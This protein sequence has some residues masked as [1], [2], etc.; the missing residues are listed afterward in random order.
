MITNNFSR[1]VSKCHSA[2]TL[3]KKALLR[4]VTVMVLRNVEKQG[5]FVRDLEFLKSWDHIQSSCLHTFRITHNGI[6]I[7]GKE[8]NHVE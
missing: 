1:T 3:K 8:G 5:R 7:G 4:R 2:E 6:E